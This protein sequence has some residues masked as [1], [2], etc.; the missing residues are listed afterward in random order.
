MTYASQCV[1][2]S[3]NVLRPRFDRHIQGLQCPAGGRCSPAHSLFKPLLSCT[4]HHNSSVIT[5]THHGLGYV[6]ISSKSVLS[7]LRDITLEA[8]YTLELDAV[9]QNHVS[10][11][12]TPHF[13]YD[14][15]LDPGLDLQM[16]HHAMAKCE[17]INSNSNSG[18]SD[19][20]CRSPWDRYRQR[21]RIIQK[22]CSGRR[23]QGCPRIHP[24]TRSP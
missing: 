11:D 10:G 7:S 19:L 9:L 21:G 17:S 15:T 18:V 12:L 23:G 24:R 1:A 14:M 16:A 4:I 3:R 6:T 20:P 8:D 13:Q 5:Q 2:L 22:R